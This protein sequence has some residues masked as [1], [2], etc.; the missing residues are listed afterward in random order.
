MRGFDTGEK[1]GYAFGLALFFLVP[2]GIAVGA[3]LG[4]YVSH[5]AINVFNEAALGHALGCG[6]PLIIA[7]AAILLL[8][9]HC[10]FKCFQGEGLKEL[11]IPLY[12]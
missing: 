8:P 10:L 3:S 5:S 12:R 6:V 11:F 7:E 4:V 9:L 2:V 1:I